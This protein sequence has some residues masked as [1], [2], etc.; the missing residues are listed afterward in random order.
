MK[1]LNL[2]KLFAFILSITIFQACSKDEPTD[3]KGGENAPFTLGWTGNDN[4]SKVPTTTNFGFGNGTLPASYSIVDK[5]PPIGDQ[6]QYGTCVSWAA[7]YNLKT[8]L[9]GIQRGL[10][11]SELANPVNQFSPK[12]LF[13][14][15][16][17]SQKGASCNGTQF[18]YALDILQNRG[19]AT[20]STVPYQNLGDCSSQPSSD[21]TQE[22]GNY[23]IKY[24][25]R[26]D[27][28]VEAVKQNISN[29]TPVVF[30]A[31]L[32]DNFMNWNSNDVISSNTTYNQVGIHSGHALIVAGYD[33]SKGPRGAFKVINSWGQSWGDDGYIW[34][35]YNFFINEFVPDFG[36]YKPL[37]IAANQD[38]EVAPPNENPDPT[39]NPQT[40]G[41]ELAPWVFADY[42]TYNQSGDLTE[43]NLDFNIYNIGTKAA[44]SSDEWAVYYIYFNAYDA[45]DYGVIFYDEFTTS[46]AQNT[47]DCPTNNNCKFNLDIPS[48]SDF[49]T[50]AFGTEY[51]YRTYNMPKITG[52]YYLLLIADGDDV[53]MENDEQDNLFYTTTY[54]INFNGGYGLKAGAANNFSFQNEKKFEA[55][56]LEFTS[57]VNDKFRNAYSKEEIKSFFKNEIN[58]ERFI[59]K[60]VTSKTKK[61]KA[62]Y[63]KTS[64]INNNK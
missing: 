17:S 42:S 51:L 44:K 18:E 24:W 22:A 36:G 7:G 49:A 11:P 40:N 64:N 21:W 58:S 27:A 39:P 38:G 60:L 59:Q 61:G 63:S 46:I 54:P 35:D 62:T 28:T 43:R 32:S 20:M 48:Q 50:E 5:F 14:A 53:F 33:D 25:R 19:I 2:I 15:I 29:N 9:S 12:D 45:N 31:Y 47:Y 23:K 8:S 1:T 6:G 26:I 10:S 57:V 4:P 34:M 52:Q 41:V 13:W 16:P 37:Y 3:G 55:N 56:N 30:G